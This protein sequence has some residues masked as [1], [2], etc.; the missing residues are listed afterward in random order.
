VLFGVATPQSSQSLPRESRQQA[1]QVLRPVLRGCRGSKG[2]YFGPIDHKR[3]CRPHAVQD[4]VALGFLHIQHHRVRIDVGQKRPRVQTKRASN[5]RKHLLQFTLGVR[6]RCSF[7]ELI[8][9]L[10]QGLAE[11]DELLWRLLRSRKRRLHDNTTQNTQRIKDNSSK[12]ASFG[13][14][15]EPSSGAMAYLRCQKGVH[16]WVEHERAENDAHPLRQRFQLSIQHIFKRRV[17]T[18]STTSK[19]SPDSAT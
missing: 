13:G 3:W 12:H 2:R 17:S 1:S 5:A 9:V 11:V 14:Q 7:V 6:N 10:E 18:R 19:T 4:P 15:S 8:L 16:V